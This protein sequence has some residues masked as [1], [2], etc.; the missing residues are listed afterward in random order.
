MRLRL[1]S[2]RLAALA[3]GLCGLFVASILPLV[4]PVRPLEPQWQL[5]ISRTLTSHGGVA[6]LGCGLL[7]LAADLQP[8]SPR[9]IRLRSTMA[10]LALPAS[11]GFLLL[12][13]L[14]GWALS[15]GSG[16]LDS[17]QVAEQRQAA[18]RIDLLRRTILEA[19][20]PIELKQ[21]F[22]ALNLP[23]L[24]ERDLARP[25]ADLRRSLLRQL[26]RTNEQLRRRYQQPAPPPWRQRFQE[27]AQVMLSAL[28]LA[29]GFAS[30]VQRPMAQ[31]PL[32]AELLGASTTR[33][34]S[35]SRPL[36]GT[37]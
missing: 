21:R 23:V 32:L 22:D 31:K 34:V 25:L 6:L 15:Q 36:R 8:Q 29:L 30:L 26:Q 28:A 27:N 18:Q 14:D 17:G 13:P 3:L 1:I 4:L 10:A 5:Q 35:P 2:W 24:Q 19:Q 9:L 20:T 7:H 11:L 37:F 33:R 12:I 16:P